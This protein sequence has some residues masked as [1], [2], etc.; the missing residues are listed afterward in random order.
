[1]DIG[2]LLTTVTQETADMS[3]PRQCLA[4]ALAFFPAPNPE[5]PTVPIQPSIRPLFS[6][7]LDSLGLEH[8]PA[9]Q[10]KWLIPG[11]HPEAGWLNTPKVVDRAEY[12]T[13]LAARADPDREADKWR[14]TA[15]ALLAQ[16]NPEMAK[17][18]AD[19]TPEQREQALR[20]GREN[21]PAALTRLAELAEKG[22]E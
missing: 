11:D 16:L 17:Q 13:W 1:M 21:L 14:P 19:M 6:E 3:D 8:N 15:E 4:W 7:L 22:E 9:K 12:E 5:M 18:I 20:A 2:S 10:R